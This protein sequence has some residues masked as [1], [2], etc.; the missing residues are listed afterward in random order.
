ME[1]PP[2]AWSRDRLRALVAQAMQIDDGEIEDSESLVEMGLDSITLM[3]LP[4]LLAA[5]GI[6]IGFGELA[7]DPRIDAWWPLLSARAEVPL[8]VPQAANPAEPFALTPV[9]RAY[10]LGRTDLFELGGVA[11]HGYV[12]LEGQDLD[13]GRLEA[14][15]NATV[16]Y[17]PMLRATV[18]ADGR[19]RVASEVPSLR[20]PAADL[21]AANAAAIVE[22]QA[23]WRAEMQQQVLPVDRWPLFDIRLALLPEGIARLHFSF[24]V[25]TL[26]L[27]SLTRW[28]TDW[29]RLYHGEAVLPAPDGP[30]FADYVRS[31]EKR[32]AGV[33]GERARHYWEERRATLP[34]SPELPLRQ[35][36]GHIGTPQFAR[37]RHDIGPADWAVLRGGA[38]RHGLT[39]S[40]L[41]LAVYASVLA[42]WS[43]RQDFCINVTLFDRAP[44]LDG[45]L[46]DFTSLILLQADLRR[47]ASIV[48]RGR[49]LQAQL[50]QD[51]DHRLVS[52]VEVM[53]VLPE[54]QTAP[55]R[56]LMPVVF[57]SAIGGE[58][59]LDALG[60]FGRVI[61]AANQ[62]PQTTLD[63][64]VLERGGALVLIWDHV[65]ALFPDGMIEA[66]AAGQ[67]ALLKQL[68][69]DAAAWT[70]PVPPLL[71]AA[72]I[73]ARC[74][75]NSTATPIASGRLHEPF[76]R[77]AMAAPDAVAVIAQDRALRY[78][79]LDAAS[80]R[81]AARLLAAGAER[82]RLIAI[83]LPRG[84]QQVV[85][86]LAV[87][88]AGAAY[89]PLD[90]A[91]PA[92][93]L[94]ALLAQGEARLVLVDEEPPVLPDAVQAVPVTAALL[95]GEIPPLPATCT[96]RPDD[97]AYVIF[98]SGSTGT[99]KGVMISHG[100]ALNTV[101]DVNN[102]FGI[103]ARDRVLAL[104]A[105]GF[106]LSVY[107]IF[108]LLAAGGAIVLPPPASAPRPEDWRQAILDHDVTVWNSVPAL[109]ALLHDH[110]RDRGDTGTLPRLRRILLSG[111]WLPVT[112]AESLARLPGEPRLVSLGGATEAAIW[113]IAQPVSRV[114]PHWTSIPYGCPLAN[115]RFHV[116]DG[117]LRPR[118]VWV[119]G[120]LYIAG[121]GLA[122]GYWRDPER[123]AASFLRH[124][125]TGEALYRT[126]DLGRYLPDGGIEFLGREDGQVKINGLRVELGEVETALCRCP[127]VTGAAALALR[128]GSRGDRLVA[129]FT[130]TADPAKLRENLATMLP[131]SLVPVAL[132]PVDSLPLTGNG[133]LD[134]R[135]LADW[136]AA[137]QAAPEP[138]IRAPADALE[139]RIADIW[140]ALL[141]IT[142]IGIDRNFFEVG[143]SSLLATRLG[144]QLSQAFG[145][146]VPVLDIFRH[147]TI[148]A[149]A[150][151]LRDA[152][153][154]AM[155]SAAAQRGAHRRLLQQR[156][157]SPTSEIVA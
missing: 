117:A 113:S 148:A 151:L 143:G 76:L 60:R 70:N 65:A 126:G 50:W 138:A 96:A 20:L 129:C 66:M 71:P 105:L 114:E 103:S 56:A 52:G 101:L 64:Q 14:A 54:R 16:A 31:L 15:L 106:D 28:L 109:M 48:E 78:A 125:E 152:A 123:S 140:S 26:D 9:Q 81:L 23:A 33:E 40:A 133:K 46:G 150:A 69:A 137:R 100:A 39:P 91:Q 2:P 86:V 147:P 98:T 44:D 156:T 120:D 130:G 82:E 61:H 116:L 32:R 97:L 42:E 141:G 74:A 34:P 131:A 112:L 153:P 128:G 121:A 144:D 43:K 108:G 79:E 1:R 102:R 12:E 136:A 77:Q 35:D 19:Q 51:M 36:P 29:H 149:Q 94:A 58:S 11:A 73:E 25:L 95:V 157:A 30:Q 4:A 67:L 21:R 62:T 115:Q 92:A 27:V 119:P 17:H 57:T 154:Q 18:G 3:R 93:R 99:P 127:G 37:I 145:R 104:S 38:A 124:P 90:P 88:K 83:A 7:R 142:S 13:P 75:A 41:L 45:V 87:L 111:D 84:W 6:T 132:W 59:Y 155:P 122:R 22:Q 107:D 24:D 55:R 53:A 72:Q 139:Q 110:L 10:W 68:A 118:P 5:E 63:H 80:S 135:R 8:S 49:A 134:R 47:S 89:L 85:A 146:E